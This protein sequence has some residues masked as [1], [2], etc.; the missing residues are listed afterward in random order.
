MRSVGLCGLSDQER[1][2][3]PMCL[4]A[5]GATKGTSPAVCRGL[6]QPCCALEALCSCLCMR[7]PSL[8]GEQQCVKQPQ[9]SS[10]AAVALKSLTL[11]AARTLDSSVEVIRA[12][13]LTTM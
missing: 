5:Q 12:A 11:G 7:A 2:G 1:S 3:M 9:L 6:S 13:C 10:P 4:A 8:A